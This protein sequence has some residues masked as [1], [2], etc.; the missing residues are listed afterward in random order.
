LIIINSKNYQFGC[1]S[2]Y[3][4]AKRRSEVKF[5]LFN[6]KEVGGNYV[7][8]VCIYIDALFVYIDAKGKKHNYYYYYYYYYYII[9]A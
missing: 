3:A 1:K 4:K 8:I 6:S 7:F 5:P 9:S 2:K